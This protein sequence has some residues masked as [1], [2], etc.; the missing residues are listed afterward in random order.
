VDERHWLLPLLDDR[1]AITFNLERYGEYSYIMGTMT[2]DMECTGLTCS[3]ITT[4]LP[5]ILPA[6]NLDSG[7]DREYRTDNGKDVSM[8]Y[9]IVI[10]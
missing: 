10:G 1:L 7:A 8:R 9:H 3:R 2:L 5:G 4:Y 6:F